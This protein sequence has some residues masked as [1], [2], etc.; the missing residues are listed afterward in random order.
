LVAGGNTDTKKAL[1]FT[2]EDPR[3][4]G[5]YLLTDGKPDSST[6]HVLK[7]IQSVMAE[8]KSSVV[9]HTISFNCENDGAN[10]FLKDLS[11]MTGGRYHKVCHDYD[12]RM[13][14]QKVIEQSKQPEV[15]L[16][17]LVQEKDRTLIAADL[18]SIDP[19][20]PPLPQLDG[21]DLSRL[22]KEI[23]ISRENLSKVNYFRQ[24]HIQLRNY[25]AEQRLAQLEEVKP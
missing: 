15:S 22:S 25:Q 12:I 6:D 3:V 13:F 17:Q 9:I 8:R 23:Q 16:E 10:Q 18:L 11:K 24:L 5:I 19:F 7:S 2:L 21:D 1:L 14:T 20:Y 4:R